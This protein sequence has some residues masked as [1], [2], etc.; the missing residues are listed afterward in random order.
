VSTP[1]PLPRGSETILL[2]EDEESLRELVREC[3]EATGYTV[4]GAKHGAE[5]LEIC[6]RHE[7]PVHLLLTDV[8]MPQMSGRELAERLGAVR[9]NIPVLYMSGYT[10]DA[11]VLHG[12]LAEGTAF[13]QKPF[14]A[15]ALARK[16]REMLAQPTEE[17][18]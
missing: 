9:P 6:E 8:V 4:L 17:S 14:G 15:E 1:V 7:G 3:L 16:V 10:D 12:V 11:V 2:V 5:A 18:P 13:L